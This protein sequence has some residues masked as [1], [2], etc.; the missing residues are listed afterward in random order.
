VLLVI[1]MPVEQAVFVCVI[2]GNRGEGRT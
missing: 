2:E 1:V